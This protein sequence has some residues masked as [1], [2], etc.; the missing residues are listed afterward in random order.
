MNLN[1]KENL[2]L[3]KNSFQIIV[4]Y[5]DNGHGK[6]LKRTAMIK[7]GKKQERE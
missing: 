6:V 1:G 4:H 7:H 3:I 5:A 2:S